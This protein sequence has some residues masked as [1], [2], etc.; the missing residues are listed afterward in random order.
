MKQNEILD[1]KDI[2]ELDKITCFVF[3]MVDRLHTKNIPLE[4]MKF[5]KK[6]ISK[7]WRKHHPL[8]SILIDGE[9]P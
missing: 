5:I 3:E 8:E 6:S 2:N 1:K 7:I 9:K 4:D